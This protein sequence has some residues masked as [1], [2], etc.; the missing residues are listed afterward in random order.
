MKNK[1]VGSV[2]SQDCYLKRRVKNSLTQ[3]SFYVME[4]RVSSNHTHNILRPSTP[5]KRS[6]KR[7]TLWERLPKG[8]RFEILCMLRYRSWR[9]SIPLHNALGQR[10]RELSSKIY[11]VSFCGI[12][13]D[14]LNH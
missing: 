10:K 6:A 8:N 7:Q 5:E 3:Y 12:P 4:Y 11:R 1:Q 14:L 13:L 9:S 2:Q